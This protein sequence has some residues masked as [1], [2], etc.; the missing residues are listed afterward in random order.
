[1]LNMKHWYLLLLTPLVLGGC[2]SHTR[3]LS[4][5]FFASSASDTRFESICTNNAFLKKY[6]CSVSRVTKDANAGNPDAEYA[7]GYLYFSGFGV[8]KNTQLARQWIQKAASQGQQLAAKALQLMPAV[9]DDQ[10]FLAVS[11]SSAGQADANST[12]F[13]SSHVGTA[14]KPQPVLRGVSQARLPK[15]GA[16]TITYAIQLMS[17]N[18]LS[19]IQAYVK[20]IKGLSGEVG[21]YSRPSGSEPAYVLLTGNFASIDAARAAIKALPESMQKQKPWARSL[22]QL[23]LMQNKV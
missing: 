23:T 12:G 22:D 8:Q 3:N 20:T 1:M 5:S 14:V 9:G 16:K 11:A 7:L 21:I 6:G 2:A 4:T 17:S 15:S 10:Q 13:G 18:N 19:S